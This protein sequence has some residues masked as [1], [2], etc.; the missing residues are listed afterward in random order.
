MDQQ[1]GSEMVAT[2]A[3]GN[4]VSNRTT[5]KS[6]ITLSG[7]RPLCGGVRRALRG[8]AG[9]VWFSLA[10]LFSCIPAFALSQQAPPDPPRPP[11]APT[12]SQPVAPSAQQ[13]AGSQA[14]DGQAPGSLSGT[15]SVTTGALLGGAQVSLVH[16][17]ESAAQVTLSGDDG[18]F[19]FAG[20]RPGAFRLTVSAEGFITQTYSGVV[21]PGE[22]LVVPTIVLAVASSVTRVSVVVP[23]V[24]IAEVEIKEEEKQRA[25]GVIPNFYVSYIPDAAPLTAKQKFELAYKSTL[26][27]VNFAI[28]GIFAGVEQAADSFHGYGQGAQGYGKRYGA[29]FADSAIGEFLGDAVFPSLLRQDPRYF[30]K[31]TG[32]KRAR[33]LYAIANAVICKSDKGRWQANYSGILGSIAAGGV[34]NLYYPP[35]DRGAGLVF[36]GVG[37]G[38]GAAAVTNLFQE[39]VVRRFTPH[40]PKRVPATP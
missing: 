12:A 38:I 40:L 15:I 4:A 22:A 35:A 32:S 31:G 14:T 21:H 16:D 39:F 5:V 9:L 18:Q 2:F 6:S 1:S 37:I 13:A 20:V 26:D 30:Y 29:G 25:L 3:A 34:S 17:D 28:V 19:S 8:R 33:I 7:R 27:P 23:R 24:E 11:A 36:E 10:A